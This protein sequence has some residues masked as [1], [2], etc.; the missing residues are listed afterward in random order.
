MAIT[1]VSSQ[2]SALVAPASPQTISINIGTRTNGLLV[3]QV[4]GTSSNVISSLTATYAAAAMTASTMTENNWTAA[5]RVIVKTFYLA[6]PTDD[7]NDLVLTWTIDSGG[8]FAD[9]Y[10]VASWWDGAFQGTALDQTAGNTGSTDPT[11]DI[12][13]SVNNEVVIGQYYS[14]A[15]VPLTKEAGE[16]EFQNHDFGANV[17]GAAYVIQTT[18]GLQTV[19]WSGTDDVFSIQAVSFK[20][21][22]GG[23][24]YDQAVSGAV[25]PS[26]TLVNSARKVL[27]GATS[28]A[29]V[30]VNSPR[31]VLSGVGNSSGTLSLRTNKVLAG[32]LTSSGVVT[33]IKLAI[34]NLAGAL[35]SS[36]ALVL[37]TS[38]Q[39]AGTLTPDGS[40]ARKIIKSFTGALTSDGTLNRR[41]TKTMAGAT[42]TAGVVAAVK[43]ALVNLGGSIVASGTLVLR[44]SKQMVGTLT[45]SGTLVKRISKSMDGATSTAGTLVKRVSKILTGATSS[46]GNLVTQ[47]I[48]GGIQ[49]LQTV[50]GAI[51]ASGALA[52]R[53][54]KQFAGTLTPTGVVTKSIRKA[55]TGALVSAGNL[56]VMIL[57]TGIPGRVI[58]SNALRGL[59]ASVETLIAKVSGTSASNHDVDGTDSDNG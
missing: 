40:L 50:G 44:T 26:G 42:S 22:A 9:L 19:D 46:A 5:S 7:T 38:K 16:T 12:T 31:K 52:L 4:C 1:L 24:Q 41:T 20:E 58:G 17:A 21:A 36:G 11:V 56:T 2:E 33:T 43:T 54:S 32:A 53:T 28:Q 6:P 34:V 18:A 27:T 59:I 10:V 35:T 57:T 49:Y 37:R 55:F 13:P 29:G 47:Y 23:T 39:L 14:R 30:L 8:S 3:V 25:T 45:P 15:N 48:S 51:V